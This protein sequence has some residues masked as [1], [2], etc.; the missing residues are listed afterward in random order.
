MD[1]FYD[2]F[3]FCLFVVFLV[4]LQPKQ[5]TVGC[6]LIVLLILGSD[7]SFLV[8]LSIRLGVRSCRFVGGSSLSLSVVCR[9]NRSKLP[10]FIIHCQQSRPVTVNRRGE[11]EKNGMHSSMCRLAGLS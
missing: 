8:C 4:E 1:R 3:F 7:C 9:S 11:G 10:F 6:S 5:V 2:C